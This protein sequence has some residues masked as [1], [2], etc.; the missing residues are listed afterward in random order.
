MALLQT[1]ATPLAVAGTAALLALFLSLSAHLAA[2]NVL[3]DVPIR[4]AFLIGPLPAAIAVA[5]GALDLPS[6]P[7]V[8]VAVVVDALLLRSVYALD[9]RLTAAVTAIHAVVSVILGSV[10]FSLY[11][12]VQSA[13][14]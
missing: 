6:L 14:G 7:A 10:L 5:A 2:R 11:V 9:R 13:P 12:L 8:A 4:N 1:A 3:G